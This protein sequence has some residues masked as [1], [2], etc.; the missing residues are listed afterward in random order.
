[1]D[2]N[3]QNIEYDKEKYL[4]RV[5]VFMDERKLIERL[6]QDILLKYR[7]DLPIN[8]SCLRDMKIEQSLTNLDQTT[9]TF[10]WNQLFT[11]YLVN[12]SQIKMDKLKEDM[13]KQCQLEYMDDK[14]EEKKIKEFD[15]NCTSDNVLEWV[16]KR[17]ICL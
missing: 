6:R 7:N 15:E 13:I 12:S 2:K 5:N 11:Y 16:Y 1:M 14:V 3:C 9:L 10:I 8:I 17:F 4:Q